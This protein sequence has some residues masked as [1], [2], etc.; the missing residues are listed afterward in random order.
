MANVKCSFCGAYVDRD[1]AVRTGLQSF[2]NDDCRRGKAKDYQLARKAP[3]ATGKIPKKHKMPDG[4][5]EEILAADGHRCRL[6]GVP[7]SALTPPEK[8][9]VHHIIYRS[10]KGRHGPEGPHVRNN[11]ISLCTK[12]HIR[13]HSDKKHFQPACQ[14][15]ADLREKTGDKDARV[16]F[17]VEFDD[18]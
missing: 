3:A 7:G 2:C 16:M 14:A 1:E 4:L 5:A 15:V 6:C 17:Y 11:L 13:V 8:V 10:E 18:D 12:C 9:D